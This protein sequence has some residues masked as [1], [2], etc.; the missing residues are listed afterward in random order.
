MSSNY[1][2]THTTP[3]AL[4]YK[5]AVRNS[6]DPSRL[7]IPAQIQNETKNEKNQIWNIWIFLIAKYKK[8]ES[9]QK[10]RCR[11]LKTWKFESDGIRKRGRN[12]GAKL[13]WKLEHQKTMRKKEGITNCSGYKGGEGMI[14]T[15]RKRERLETVKH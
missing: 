5:M 7:H 14:G 4:I 13:L 1:K 3:R 10:R 12:F 6:D 2:W 15:D 11:P 9:V 8:S